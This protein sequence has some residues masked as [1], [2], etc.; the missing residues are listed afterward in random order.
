[1]LDVL[2]NELQNLGSPQ[3]K[4]IYLNHGAD[5]ELFGVKTAD[6]KALIKKYKLKNNT[7]LALELF[8]THNI[9]AMYLAVLIAGSHDISQ[10]TLDSW[11]R[12]ST[13][14]NL[15][16][17]GCAAIASEAAFALSL[18]KKWMEDEFDSVIAAG[19]ACYNKYLQ[20]T[21]KEKL[22]LDEIKNILLYIQDNI[23]STKYKNF[24]RSRYAMN[25]FVLTVGIQLAECSDYCIEVAKSYGKLKIDFGNTACKV[26][27]VAVGIE[28]AKMQ[29]RIGKIKK[30]ARC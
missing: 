7:P 4:Q 1:M 24:D 15:T 21:P 12:V 18:A 26:P 23:N 29:N 14:S 13:F 19:Y 6:I 25:N 30:Q 20:I 27:D 2:M 3:I 22:N 9:D 11:V 5:L 17:Y 16:D 10:E 8:A 28:K